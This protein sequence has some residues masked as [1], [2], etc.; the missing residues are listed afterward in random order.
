MRIGKAFLIFESAS[1][2]SFELEF[3]NPD[4]LVATRHRAPDENVK[5][6]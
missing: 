6:S 1:D 4:V 3:E 2:Q 5:F